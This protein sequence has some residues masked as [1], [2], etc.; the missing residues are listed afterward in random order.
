MS[1]TAVWMETY[2]RAV[3]LTVRR[4]ALVWWMSPLVGEGIS[5]IGVVATRGA[6]TEKRAAPR[7]GMLQ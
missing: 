5:R 7:G 6:A 2:L 1:A 4:A 3:T